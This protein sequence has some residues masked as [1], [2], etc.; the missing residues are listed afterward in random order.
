MASAAFLGAGS[1][2]ADCEK[3]SATPMNGILKIV[4][5]ERL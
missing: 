1:A 3:W 4:T 2:A 5:N